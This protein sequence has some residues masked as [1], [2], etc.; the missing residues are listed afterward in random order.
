MKI[1]NVLKEIGVF[2]LIL[3]FAIVTSSIDSILDWLMY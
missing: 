2:I 3:I 1:K